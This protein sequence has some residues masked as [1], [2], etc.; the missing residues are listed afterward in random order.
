MGK[1]IL[2][3]VG[4]NG[5]N[6]AGSKAGNDVLRVSQECGYKLIPL[7]ES[8]QVRTRVQDII[9]GVIA[10]YS[11]RNKLVDGDIVLMQ[12]PLNRL[13][14]KN[15]FRI[16]KRCKSNIRIATLIHDIDYLRD[17]PLGDKGV[18]GMKVLELSLLG[19]SD[20]LICHN[21]FMI[22]TLQKEKLS[23]EYISLD[24][25]DYL[26]D[27]T[28]ATISEDKSTVIVAGNLLESKAGYLYQIKK[29]KHKFALSLYGS[30]YAVDK[31]QMDNA[32]YHGSFKPDELIANLY[33]AY[34]LVW[35]GSS[36]ETCSG[37]YGKYLRINNPHKV[38]LYIAAGIPVVI[39]KEA[40][41]CSL[42]EENALGFG[43]SS[44]DELE[45]ALKSHEHLYQSYRNNVL[46]MKEKVCSGGFLKYVLVQ[47][48]RME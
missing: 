29:D 25:F 4:A 40:A 45:E 34:G 26:Y 1:Y 20:Y 11:L 9:S 48:D 12:Y 37:S 17:I 5:Q 10:T 32:T 23:V 28:P 24:L 43:I 46:N 44:L 21:P 3:V 16:L 36:T 15:I 8:N 27:G 30:N 13:L 35:D 41:L 7:Y 33:G 31:M 42:I 47:I 6:N 18:D 19:S 14:M 39:W 38:S 22:R 2:S